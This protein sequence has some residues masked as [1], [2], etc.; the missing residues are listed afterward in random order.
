MENVLGDSK[1]KESHRRNCFQLEELWSGPWLGWAGES[2]PSGPGTQAWPGSPD[3]RERSSHVGDACPPTSPSSALA[4]APS[5]GLAT[6]TPAAHGVPGQL[7]TCCLSRPTVHPSRR[8]GPLSTR[9]QLVV[10]RPCTG[11]SSRPRPSSGATAC[12]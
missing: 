5:R 9:L 1:K 8:E 3:S 10:H 7:S 6:R 2:Q 12:L 4:A 11:L